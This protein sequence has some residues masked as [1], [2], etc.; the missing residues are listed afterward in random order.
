MKSATATAA[1]CSRCWPPACATPSRWPSGP[2]RRGEELTLSI[3]PSDGMVHRQQPVAE[4]PG[5]R[6]G[7]RAGPACAAQALSRPPRDATLLARMGDSL[8]YAPLAPV[9]RAV[10]LAG[11][12]AAL[13]PELAGQAAY[14][15]SPRRQPGRA[16]HAHGLVRLRG[17]H[18]AARPAACAE[19][20][21]WPG[22]EPRGRCACSTR[23]TCNRP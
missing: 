11:A 18:C 7:P 10:A 2:R 3:Y 1:N 19:I 14:R 5:Q 6:P 20:A 17:A 13:L 21:D 15:V 22:I 8:G 9:L 12:R 23:C 16:D 4:F